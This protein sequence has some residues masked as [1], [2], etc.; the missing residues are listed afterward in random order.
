[1]KSLVPAAGERCSMQLMSNKMQLETHK[2]QPTTHKQQTAPIV[3][4][5]KLKPMPSFGSNKRVMSAARASGDNLAM[6]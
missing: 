6:L 5:I 4:R 3:T 2:P 1:M